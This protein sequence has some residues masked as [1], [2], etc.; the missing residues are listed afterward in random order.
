M[1]IP[2]GLKIEMMG[3][4]YAGSGDGVNVWNAG[5]NLVGKIL[6]QGGVANFAFGELGV[7]FLLNEERLYRIDLS[8][9]I[10]T[11]DRRR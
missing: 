7:M 9:E 3:N 4:V 11:A 10:M 5:G 1:G 8:R 2:D 6:V